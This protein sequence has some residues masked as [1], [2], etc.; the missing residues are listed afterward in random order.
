VDAKLRKDFH[1]KAD[2][3]K[4]KWAKLCMKIV[5][6]SSG[7]DVEDAMLYIL[8]HTQKGKTVARKIA[9]A[10]EGFLS[11]PSSL[12]FH[13][14]NFHPS[15]PLSNHLPYSRPDRLSLFLS[16]AAIAFSEL[17]SKSRVPFLVPFAQSFTR[18]TLLSEGFLLTRGEYQ[19]ARAKQVHTQSG[20]VDAISEDNSSYTQAVDALHFAA[21]RSQPSRDVRW[22][23]RL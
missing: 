11:I 23:K 21:D 20:E 14:H 4:S 8:H 3:T 6:A 1:S 7:T 17:D 2:D 15:L 22:V 18:S 19:Y 13:P 10:E 12:K 5:A 16:R 9:K